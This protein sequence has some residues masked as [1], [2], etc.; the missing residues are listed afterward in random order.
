MKHLDLFPTRIWVND[1]VTIDNNALRRRCYEFA[2]NSKSCILSN[3]GGYQSEGEFT[4]IEFKDAILKTLPHPFYK[5]QAVNIRNVYPWLN[6]NKNGNWNTPHHHFAGDIYVCGVYYVST[7]PESGRIRF[8]DPRSE[9]I[10][11]T[12]SYQYLESRQE[13]L[14]VKPT[15]GLV[16]FFP[17]WLKHDVEPN[18]SDQDRVSIAFNVILSNEQTDKIT[19]QSRELQIE[20]EGK[21]TP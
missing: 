7:P 13:Q 11:A 8:Y 10:A 1:N 12:G 2:K 20:E 15:E 5:G 3:Q 4:D 18:D 6:I 16:V 14:L 19:E 9:Y 17:C 21:E